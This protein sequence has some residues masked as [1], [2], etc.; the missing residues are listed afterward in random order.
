MH[1]YL[2]HGF[3]SNVTFRADG[4]M[5]TEPRSSERVECKEA[6]APLSGNTFSGYGSRIPTGYMIKWR[7]KWRRVYVRCFSNS[8]TTYIRDGKARIVVSIRHHE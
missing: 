3:A 2:E 4:G 6:T 1:A 7:G 8:G 5:V